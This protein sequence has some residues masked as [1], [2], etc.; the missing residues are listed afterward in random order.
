[1]SFLSRP[2]GMG[3][4]AVLSLL[5]ASY[6]E[7]GTYEYYPASVLR[8]G[9][10][11]DPANLSTSFAPC[12][13][14]N[15]EYAVHRLNRDAG[16][17]PIPLAP[18]QSPN[19]AAENE[20]SI[21]QIKTR[22]HLYDFLNV[23]V[24]ASGNYGFFGASA[25]ANYQS[26]DTFD[27][28]SFVFGVRGTTTFAE[29]GLVDPQLTPEVQKLTSNPTAFYARCGHEWVTQE[30]RGVLIAVVYTIKNVS[31]SQ[32]SKLEAAVSGGFNSPA[33]G[34]NVS[35]N[36]TKIVQS[37]FA[38]NF[39]SAKIH[40]IGG[41]GVSDFATTITNIDDPVA[42]LKTISDYMKTLTYEN[43]VPLK[44][45][46]GSLD[47]FLTQQNPQGLFDSYNRRI[48]DLF[49]SYED[50]L[51][52]RSKVWQFLHQD[53]QSVWG[54]PLDEKAWARIDLLD[55]VIGKVEAKAQMCRKAAQIA[56]S[57]ISTPALPPLKGKPADTKQRDFV[58]DFA[59]GINAS[60]AKSDGAAQTAAMS[61]LVA[62]GT[63]TKTEGDCRS[64]EADPQVKVG[65]EALCE[66]LSDTGVY[67][68]SRFAIN[69][70]PH[71]T[72]VHD[73]TLA[74]ST[75]LYVSVTSAANLTSVKLVDNTGTTVTTLTGGYDP[76][77]GPVWYGSTPFRNSSGNAPSADK[78]P[79][80]VQVVDAFG[81]TYSKP[82]MP[83]D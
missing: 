31:Q 26:E 67:L 27:S 78:L 38:S 9:G 10:T 33:L 62:K 17:T 69:A 37:A 75:L 18:G 21:Q 74:P 16:K 64:T 59:N 82:V 60:L 72:V 61:V 30:S 70:V 56:T 43:S 8:L 13:Q 46:T 3:L 77:Q 20:L 29:V 68:K 35:A 24:A 32:R 49:L 53:T 15:R 71:I 40:F 66:C 58:Y 28:D 6:C 52:Q 80:V 45:T 12:I 57:L 83:L 4:A 41:N 1:M 2:A 14:Y 47:Q 44:F 7:A 5:S 22:Q 19:V 73:K 81:R 65:R 76:E 11:L 51:D 48:A 79:Y 34:V 50:Y 25:S 36:M 55:S 23:S 63:G 54:A 39:Y 42:V